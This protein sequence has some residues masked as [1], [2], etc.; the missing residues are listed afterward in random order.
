[1]LPTAPQRTIPEHPIGVTNRLLSTIRDRTTTIWCMS[2]KSRLD[3]KTSESSRIDSRERPDGTGSG[4]D[5]HI[6]NHQRRTTNTAGDFRSC[7]CD[8][9][10]RPQQVQRIGAKAQHRD[11]CLKKYTCIMNKSKFQG[12][13]SLIFLSSYQKKNS[14]W[15]L[16]WI[17]C[18]I[19][20]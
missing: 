12:G 19:S 15:I 2:A 20:S 3:L 16:S 1:M 4:S 7:P 5:L 14:Y 10:D 8:R 6:G 18:P 9:G 17:L 11:H 13:T